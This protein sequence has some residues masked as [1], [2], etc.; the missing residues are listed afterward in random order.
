M[1][2]AMRLMWDDAHNLFRDRS[3]PDAHEEIGL[4]RV[5]LLPFVTNCSAA[6]VLFR[7][8]A[9]SGDHEFAERAGVVLESLGGMAA[10]QGPQAAHYLLA[11]RASRL[12]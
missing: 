5:P 11:L 3:A 2:H 1:K 12:R 8:T 7:L 6:S 10:E 4:M 9:T